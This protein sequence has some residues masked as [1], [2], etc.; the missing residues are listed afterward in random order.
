MT[1][2]LYGSWNFNRNHEILSLETKKVMFSNYSPC[3]YFSA[4]DHET[5]W[6]AAMSLEFNVSVV[7]A[8]NSQ[9]SPNKMPGAIP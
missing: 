6:F 3:Q 1:G 2:T 8:T 9:R 7:K 5:V 4:P